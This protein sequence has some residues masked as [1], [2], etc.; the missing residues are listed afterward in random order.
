MIRERGLRLGPLGLLLAV[1]A[2]ALATLATLSF[3]SARA[4]MILTERFAETVGRLGM[5]YVEQK[6]L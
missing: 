2:I 3:S 6:L 1:I 5:D 4:D